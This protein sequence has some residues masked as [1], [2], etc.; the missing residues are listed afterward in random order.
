LGSKANNREKKDKGDLGEQL[1]AKY[2]ME[3]GYKIR[4]KNWRYHPYEIDLVAEKN[5]LIIFV[6]V[7]LREDWNLLEAWETV[8]KAQQRR[9]CSAAHEYLI[10]KELD[11][12]ARFDIIGVRVKEGKVDIEHYEDAFYP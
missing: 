5:G 10:L 6:E 9:I 2:L 12:E 3:N 4:H 11:V 7:K 8:S 1:A